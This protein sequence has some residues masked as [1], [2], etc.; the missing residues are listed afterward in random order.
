[1]D[2]VSV[3]VCV[4]ELMIGEGGRLLASQDLSAGTV[5]TVLFSVIIGAFSLGSLGPRVEAF[6]KAHAAA[7]KIGQTLQRIPPIDSFVDSGEKPEGIKGNIELKN[8][9]FIYPSRPEGC[10]HCNSSYYS[11]GSE[12]C[13]HVHPR[14]KVYC[15][16]WT[17]RVRQID[18][19]AIGGT[20][21]RPC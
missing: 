16:R 1:M 17:I 13:Q 7:Q 20:L 3:V 5:L 2:L 10:P 8:V 21:L 9:S 4:S 15:G 12:E 14:G 19:P 6:A 18:Y 11:H